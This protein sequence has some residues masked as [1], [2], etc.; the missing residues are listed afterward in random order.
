MGESLT[1]LRLQHDSECAKE[2]I[3][4]LRKV[5]FSRRLALHAENQTNDQYQSDQNA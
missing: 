5:L 2:R 4:S 3:F 1:Q